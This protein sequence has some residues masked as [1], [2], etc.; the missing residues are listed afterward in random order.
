MDNTSDHLEHIEHAQHAAHASRFDRFVAMSMAVI[1]AL[2][3]AVTMLSHRAH[4]ETLRFQ[5]EANRLQSEANILHTQ[6]AD[7]WAFYQAKNIRRHEYLALANLLKVTAP[8]VGKEKEHDKQIQAWEGK[9]KEYE[10][11]ADKNEIATEDNEKKSLKVIRKEAENLEAEA[12]QKR[13]EAT[14]KLAESKHEHHRGLWLDVAELGVELGLVLCSLA[15]LTKR[16][17][18]WYS[19]LTAAG[20]GVLL[21]AFAFLMH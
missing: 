21:A 8:L 7:Q 14:E 10:G 5:G 20:I 19:G 2:L 6:A 11:E 13:A 1:A 4:N 15:V 16:P 3:A 18:F 12:K 9:A 17:A